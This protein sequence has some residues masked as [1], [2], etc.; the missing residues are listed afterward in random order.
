[1]TIALIVLVAQ[2]AGG[3]MVVGQVTTH[4]ATSLEL[5][6]WRHVDGIV[7]TQPGVVPKFP[8]NVKVFD[9]T[10]TNPGLV[11]DAQERLDGL[12]QDGSFDSCLAGSVT[13]K[14]EFRFATLGVIT[15]MYTGQADCT[16]WD[17]ITLGNVLGN[18]RA[19]VLF[20]GV[21]VAYASLDGVEILEAL[22]KRT[23]MPVPS[24]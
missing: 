6:A 15:Q 24:G 5:I 1:M 8:P 20:S 18:L 7:E 2:A 16:E 3:Y 9:K 23:G 19:L 4:G 21:G 11:H 10:I 22:H 14:Y 12:V 17:V 13:Y